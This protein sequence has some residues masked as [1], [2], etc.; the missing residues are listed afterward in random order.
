MI[1]NNPFRPGSWTRAQIDHVSSGWWV[2]LVTGIVSILAGGIILLADWTVSDLVIFV[3]ALLLFHG[4]FTMFSVPVDGA[5]WGW[6]VALGLLEAGFGIAVWVWPG[7]SLSVL[8]AFIGFYVLVSGIVTIAGAIGG[9]DV[10]PYWGLMLALGI[11]ETLFSFW[12]L[13][14]P[15]ITL[16]AA[17][18]AI[19]L[20]SLFY[21]VMQIVLAFELKSLPARSD[22]AAASLDDA[23]PLGTPWQASA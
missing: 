14:E 15:G 4:I 22:A 3:G 1:V 16:V 13:A 19:G 21:G 8:A 11:I 7:A 12:L 5:A 20:W 10:I 9:R 6:S 23:A 18:L 17:V 2:L